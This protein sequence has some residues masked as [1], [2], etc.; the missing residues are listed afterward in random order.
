VKK[1]C[2]IKI[3]GDLLTKKSLE[4]SG[5]AMFLMEFA[6]KNHVVICVGGGSQINKAFKKAGF[7]VGKFG[8]FGRET[9]SL[10]QRQLARD[11]LEKNQ[12]VLQDWLIAKNIS[13]TVEIPVIQSG[14]VLCH[15]NGDQ[16][17]LTAYNGFDKIYVVTTESRLKKKIEQFKEYPKIEVVGFHFGS[18]ITGP[19][20]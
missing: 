15:V 16:Y 12:S 2:L 13:A 11:I 10:K 8:P 20:E 4:K 14:T 7:K 6:Y 17:V 19:Y 9:G 18:V 1:N 3:S 5:L